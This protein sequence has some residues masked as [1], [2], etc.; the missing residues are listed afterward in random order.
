[1]TRLFNTPIIGRSATTVVSSW[2]DIEAGLS[3]MYCR[4]MPPD[5]WAAAVTANQ[6]ENSDR[7]RRAK[8]AA[9]RR[10]RSFPPGRSTRDRS[11][12]AGLRN[13]STPV[14]PRPRRRSAAGPDHLPF[15]RLLT[16]L[17][18]RRRT[19]RR[20]LL[21]EPLRT[22]RPVMEPAARAPKLLLEQKENYLRQVIYIRA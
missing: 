6:P 7:N 20:G 12:L 2:I 14:A 13:D 10:H 21:T 11:R 5:F 9:L 18:R 19:F 17:C 3:M 8:D 1:M 15:W 4:R 16:A 22:S